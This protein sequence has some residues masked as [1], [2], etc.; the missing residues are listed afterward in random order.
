MGL[1]NTVTAPFLGYGFG[2]GFDRGFDCGFVP[3]CGCGCRSWVICSFRGPYRDIA[4]SLFLEAMESRLGDNP[5]ILGFLVVEPQSPSRGEW[6][7]P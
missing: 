1:H 4:P 6:R 7:H 3:D 2:H 5:R